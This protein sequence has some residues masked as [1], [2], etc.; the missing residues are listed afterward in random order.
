M[1]GVLGVA[2]NYYIYLFYIH[3]RHLFT[4]HRTMVS[5]E[6]H[7]NCNLFRLFA[8]VSNS[9]SYTVQLLCGAHTDGIYDA[10]KRFEIQKL[11]Q[12]S[13]ILLSFETYSFPLFSVLICCFLSM[14]HNVIKIK[15]VSLL[16]I[17]RRQRHKRAHVYTNGKGTQYIF[18]ES[19]TN[20]TSNVRHNQ[21][22]CCACAPRVR[23]NVIFLISNGTDFLFVI[24]QSRNT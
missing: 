14:H 17:I 15:R 18:H 2:H 21:F 10:M 23:G 19:A 9:R 8:I 6:L 24:F 20:E 3:T 22:E 12:I 7:K 5:C 11:S 13:R 16:V 1:C 4:A